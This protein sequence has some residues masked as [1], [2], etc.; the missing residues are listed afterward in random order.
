MGL[1]VPLL[2]GSFELVLSRAP[3]ITHRFYGVLFTKYGYVGDALLTVLADAAGA[4]W[5]E[6]LAKEW[7]A[8]YGAITSIMLQGAAAAA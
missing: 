5:N 8:A 4:D 1:N 6:E 3:D 7:G 2:R